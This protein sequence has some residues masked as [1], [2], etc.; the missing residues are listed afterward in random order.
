[1]IRFLVIIVAAY[2]LYRALKSWMSPKA[3]DAGASRRTPV[4]QITDVMIQD[5]YCGTYFPSR[6]G[7]AH[8]HEGKELMFC[9]EACKQKYIEQHAKTTGR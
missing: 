5:P 7:I 6:E 4:G 8:T 1:M 3:P 9:S 2:V